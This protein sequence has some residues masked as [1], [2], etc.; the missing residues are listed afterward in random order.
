MG[1][2]V[3][4]EDAHFDGKHVRFVGLDAGKS[5]LCGVTTNALKYC[6]GLP[7][8]GLIPAEEFVAAYRA[9]MIDIH[10]IAGEKHAKGLFEPG[11]DVRIVVHRRDL[12]P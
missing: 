10:R 8:Y 1:R 7:H 11:D 6:S 4:L 3:F 9:R 5:V 12:M 2:L